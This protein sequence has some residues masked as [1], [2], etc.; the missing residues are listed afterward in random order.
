MRFDKKDMQKF[1]LYALLL[2]IVVVLIMS[3]LRSISSGK[4][5]AG[6]SFNALE[7]DAL[8]GTLIVYVF[9]LFGLVW[10]CKSYFFEFEKGW[11]FT[12]EKKMD[13]YSKWCDKKTMQAEL[14]PVNASEY[15]SKYA[16]IPLINDG[17]TLWVDDGEYHNLIIGSTGSGKTQC[18][19]FPMVEVL[20]KHNESMV[21]TDPKGEI[22]QAKAAMLRKRGYKLV[23]L[24]FRSPGQGNAWN[25][26]T[27]PYKLWKEGNQD[28]SCE[29]LDDLAANILYDEGNKNADPF[30]EKTSAGYF[31]G[32]ALGLFEDATEEQVNINSISLMSTVGEERFG[33]STYVK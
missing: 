6:L 1:G 17:K 18:I 9:T 3:N 25:P 32:L 21:I 10:S 31:S 27:I 2:F 4:G 11:G 33:P 24:N 8:P 20:A 12:T 19:I 28:K 15:N 23:V 13:G 29:L 7:L 22:Y 26:L 30:W 5:F 16:G 14:K